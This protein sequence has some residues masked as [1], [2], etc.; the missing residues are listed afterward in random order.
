MSGDRVVVVENI[1]N[2]RDELRRCA[3][4]AETASGFVGA[5]AMSYGI[6]VV[7]FAARA[8]SDQVADVASDVCTGKRTIESARKT[9]WIILGSMNSAA[10]YGDEIKRWMNEIDQA[11]D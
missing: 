3:D 2:I 4:I 10:E 5:G 8:L 11:K 7:S 1:R 9:L 6:D